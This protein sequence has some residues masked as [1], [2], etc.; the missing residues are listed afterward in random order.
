M[1]T[2]S[3]S[4]S[5]QIGKAGTAHTHTHTHTQWNARLLAQSCQTLWP[6]G[7]WPTRLLCPWDSPG[8]NTG[9]A[10]HA[11][12]QE[13]FPTQGLNPHLFMSPE[14]A[15]RFFTTSTTWEA[16]YD[17]IVLSHKKE[18]NFVICSNLN[19]LEGHY[20][21]WNKSDE[22]KVLYGIACMWNLKKIQQSNE[23]TK[24]EAAHSNREQ[25]GGYQWKVGGQRKGE[26]GGYWV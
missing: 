11:L 5:R 20:G 18:P 16:P 1:K 9:V 2:T 10:C 7:L 12:L 4:I 19:G 14:L 21:N 24:K 22:G 8:K 3:V 15:G 26:R 17:E 13:I 25:T 6:C 23:R